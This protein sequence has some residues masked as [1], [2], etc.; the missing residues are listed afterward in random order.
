MS[1][2]KILVSQTEFSAINISLCVFGTCKNNI[3]FVV[4]FFFFDII[5]RVADM[6]DFASRLYDKTLYSFNFWN[7][8]ITQMSKSQLPV[9]F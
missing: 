9:D 7:N 2:I 4:A 3:K 5:L 1:H 8:V 6:E